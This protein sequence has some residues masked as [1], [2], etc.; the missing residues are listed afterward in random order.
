MRFTALEL[1]KN[2][3]RSPGASRVLNYRDNSGSELT[4]AFSDD[5]A[6]NG[7][8]VSGVARCR[9]RSLDPT[10]HDANGDDDGGAYGGGALGRAAQT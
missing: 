7:G 6:S 9:Y 3:S 2:N 1:S 10:I 5:G 4:T 8:G